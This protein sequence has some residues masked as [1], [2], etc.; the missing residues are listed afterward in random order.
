VLVNL[1]Q[2]VLSQMPVFR[3]ELLHDCHTEH[4][5]EWLCHF[6]GLGVKFLC[7][8]VV[9]LL[10][11]LIFQ[12]EIGFLVQ[13]RD[14]HVIK[15]IR[16]RLWLVQRVR[17][18]NWISIRRVFHSQV[19]CLEIVPIQSSDSFDLIIVLNQLIISIDWKHVVL[20]FIIHY[21]FLGQGD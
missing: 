8:H 6:S 10:V 15:G 16:I 9:F 21:Q 14:H 1:L 19:T 7:F 3:K 20:R 5:K 4:R 12:G 17:K 18:H 11:I 2:R 13:C